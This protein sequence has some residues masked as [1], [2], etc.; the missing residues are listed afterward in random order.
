MVTSKGSWLSRITWATARE[1]ISNL[2][3]SYLP[4]IGVPI[5]TGALGILEGYSPT[6]IFLSC[7]VAFAMVTLG[8]NQF[9][10]WR[11]AR[12]PEGK[13]QFGPP[14]VAVKEN[15]KKGDFPVVQG[16]K[17]G[18][19][20][21]SKAQ[22]P[23]E[24]EVEELETQVGDRVPTEKFTKSTMAIGM[25][26]GGGFVSAIIDLAKDISKNAVLPGSIKAKVRYGRPGNLKHEVEKYLYLALT[27][28]E[29]GNLENVETSLTD[30]K[31]E[32]PISGKEESQNQ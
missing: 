30:L 28:D 18:L 1:T 6:L 9:S 22:F 31:V 26:G 8:L 20:L 23:L 13:L 27:F 11:A 29:R 15:E 5:M 19:S 14:V 3:W 24:A 32:K 10:Q 21:V 16:L 2:A 4:I 25:G 12:T 7:L 17:L